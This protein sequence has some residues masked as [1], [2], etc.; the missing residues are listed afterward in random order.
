MLNNVDVIYD[1]PEDATFV[2]CYLEP[3]VVTTLLVI[4]VPQCAIDLT[5]SFKL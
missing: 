2:R 5:L 3:Q 1:G 4:G